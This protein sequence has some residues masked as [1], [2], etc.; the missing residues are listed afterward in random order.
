MGYNSA[1]V[2]I[3]DQSEMRFSTLSRRTFGEV[4]KAENVPDT[5]ATHRPY[6]QHARANI[7]DVY[8]M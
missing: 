8:S 6:S 4:T 3:G 5:S 2:I 1:H 7:G